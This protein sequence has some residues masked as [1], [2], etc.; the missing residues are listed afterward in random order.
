MKK[1]VLFLALILLCSNAANAAEIGYISYQKVLTNYGPAKK[2]IAELD[3]KG[4]DIKQYIMQQEIEVM[5]TSDANKKVVR[6]KTIKD[7]NA[8]QEEYAKLKLK[9]EQELSKSITAAINA[10]RV[11]KKLDVILDST[12]VL[13]GGINCTE[14]V[15]KKLNVSK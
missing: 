11:E 8:K 10:V 12:T 3:K 14:D 7:L 15:L 2:A 6:Q 13:S 1:I 4:L 5:K 9:K